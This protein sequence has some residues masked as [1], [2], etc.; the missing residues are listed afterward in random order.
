MMKMSDRYILTTAYEITE[1]TKCVC[2][3]SKIH[4]GGLTTIINKYG[5]KQYIQFG[6]IECEYEYYAE[7]DGKPIKYTKTKCTVFRPV[8]IK[9]KEE[10]NNN[11][12]GDNK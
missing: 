10:Q 6:C 1:F 3:H 9:S 2:G 4:H 7:E 8:F 12:G 5:N 11:R